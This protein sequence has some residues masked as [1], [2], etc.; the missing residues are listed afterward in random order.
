MLVC[1]FKQVNLNV[2]FNPCNSAWIAYHVFY[3]MGFGAFNVVAA[4]FGIDTHGGND[5]IC[6]AKCTQICRGEGLALT[7]IV[8]GGVG[9]NAVAALQMQVLGA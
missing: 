7:L 5:A 9:N 6:E 8:C 1:F 4:I 2:D 3:R